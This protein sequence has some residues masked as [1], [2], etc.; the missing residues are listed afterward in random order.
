MSSFR[1]VKGCGLV[2]LVLIVLLPIIACEYD[3]P[4]EIVS[5]VPERGGNMVGGDGNLEIE[6]SEAV[7]PETLELGLWTLQLDEEQELLPPCSSEKTEQCSKRLAGPCRFDLSSDP[8]ISDQDRCL[9][10][11]IQSCPGAEISLQLDC[12]NF[13][14]YQSSCEKTDQGVESRENTSLLT[15]NP[16]QDLGIGTYVLRVSAGLADLSGHDTGAPLDFTFGVTPDV[17]NTDG[18]QADGDTADGDEGGAP[19][20]FESGVF[21]SWMDLDQPFDYPLEV[22]W[23]FEVNPNTGRVTGTGCDADPIDVNNWNRDLHK[24]EEVMPYPYYVSGYYFNFTATVSDIDVDGEPGYY[25]DTDPF[26]I[27]SATPIT[28]EVADGKIQ[29]SIVYDETLGREKMVGL[30]NSPETYVFGDHTNKEPSVASGAVYGYRL[31]EEEV[32]ALKEAF[33]DA[34]GK[35]E[36]RDYVPSPEDGP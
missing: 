11:L 19:T 28:V 21:V 22:Y 25:F 29:V 35:C 4:P 36:S 9:C 17:G 15:V 16:K 26:V 34:Y 6:F 23:I 10:S 27:Y 5:S 20:G 24:H 33:P 13:V 14:K 30:L 7:K 31:T 8:T 32:T 1:S 2:V 18:D 12:R 3:P